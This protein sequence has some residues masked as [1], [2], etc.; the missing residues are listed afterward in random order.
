MYAR[1]VQQDL[2]HKSQRKSNSPSKRYEYYHLRRH[3]KAKEM[4]Y[5]LK[6]EKLERLAQQARSDPRLQLA[7]LQTIMKE[8]DK[9]GVQLFSKPFERDQKKDVTLPS[10]LYVMGKLQ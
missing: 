5:A 1:R 3:R 6:K 8:H 7:K 4:A 10:E 9:V 2:H